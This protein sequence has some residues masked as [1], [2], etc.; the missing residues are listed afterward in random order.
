MDKKEI[1]KVLMNDIYPKFR[2]DWRLV[3][4][5]FDTYFKFKIM[6]KEWEEWRNENSL[7]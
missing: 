1:I 2:E 6:K 3:K 4:W 7:V 5:H